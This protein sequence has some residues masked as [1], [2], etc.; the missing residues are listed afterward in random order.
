MPEFLAAHALLPEGW[1]RDV[2]IA[3]DEAG[4]ITDVTPGAPRGGPA[5]F[6]RGHVIPGVGNLHSHAF[7]RAMAGGAE[8]RS[9]A[10]RDSFWSW[11]ETMYRFALTISPEDA[12]AIGAMVYAECLTRG[13]THV[14]EFHYLHHA[15]DGSPYVDRSEMAQ[16]L[17]AAAEA[18]GIGI[19]MLPSLYRHGGIFGAPPHEGQR[20]FLNDLDGFQEIVNRVR[21]TA[22][23]QR[24]AAWGVAPHSLR[25][26]TPAMLEAMAEFDAPIHIHAAEQE[27]EVQECLHAT[28]LR[29]VEWLLRNCPLDRRWVLI[30]ATHMSEAETRELAATGAV[31][32][33]CPSTEASLGDGIF[34]LPAYL[35]AGGILGLGTDSHVGTDPAAEIRQL[36]TSQRLA[37]ELRSVATDTERPHPGRGLLERALEGGAQACGVAMGAIAVGK[38]CDLVELDDEHPTLVGREGDGLLDA[39]A[40]GPAD[41]MSRSVAVGGVVVVESGRHIREG[42]IR[43]GF[44]TVMRK[45]G[46]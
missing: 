43:E 23:R 34:P 36:E 39:W 3:S 41:R 18:A 20:R 30:H 10:G 38:R 11:R 44:A 42:T 1:R 5:H 4:L 2:R 12:Q 29:P 37:L 28:G 27:K 32:G 14:A 22:G 46:A 26:V 40:F 15:P 17:F 35:A 24:N 45:L 21:A 19:T 25:A 16:R 7:Q 9:P 6:L 13:F 31:A 8:R 33:L